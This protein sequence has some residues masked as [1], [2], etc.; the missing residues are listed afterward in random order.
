MNSKNSSDAY[1]SLE[2]TKRQ[3]AV[4]DLL[5]KSNAPLTDK[6]IKDVLG[7]SK[8]TG[9]VTDMIFDGRVKKFDDILDPRTGVSV[10]RVCLAVEPP[11]HEI[12]AQM[13]TLDQSCHANIVEILERALLIMKKAHPTS[14]IRGEVLIKYGSRITHI[15]C[16]NSDGPLEEVHEQD[17]AAQ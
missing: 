1:R 6:E 11:R 17:K 7:F 15:E 14:K 4:V 8:T 16:I 13:S 10:R 9:I 5:Q 2:I 12:A 3:Q